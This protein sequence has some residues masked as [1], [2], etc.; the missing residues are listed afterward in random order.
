MCVVGLTSFGFVLFR[1]LVQEIKVAFFSRDKKIVFCGVSLMYGASAES[2]FPYP[3]L[4]KKGDSKMMT[5]R[6]TKE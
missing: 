6:T 5:I 2:F 4:L 1:Y 3:F